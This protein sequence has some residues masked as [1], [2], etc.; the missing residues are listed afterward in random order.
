MANKIQADIL[1]EIDKLPEFNQKIIKQII[2]Q[3]GDNKKIRDI[4]ND[5]TNEIFEF[6]AEGD[7]K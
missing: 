3:L 5:I 4:R 6:I 1:A 2:Q 7:N